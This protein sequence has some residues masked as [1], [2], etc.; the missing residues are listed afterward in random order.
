MKKTTL[1]VSLP[2]YI[3]TGFMITFSSIPGDT[4]PEIISF[5][6]WDKLAHFLEYLVFSML[7]F[8]F[9]QFRWSMD[10]SR[11]LILTITVATAFA[12]LDEIHQLPIPNRQC[13]WQDIVADLA[14][15]LTGV[16]IIHSSFRRH[17]V[18]A[19]K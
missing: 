6:Q 5:W 7:L 14:G 2:L 18:G 16:V 9:I 12:V 15:I 8:R 11:S 3:W 17:Q 10:L 19:E 4:F 13:R 1:T